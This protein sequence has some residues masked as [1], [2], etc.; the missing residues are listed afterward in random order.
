M[1]K[2]NKMTENNSETKILWN[3]QKINKSRGKIYI[4]SMKQY[5]FVF[6]TFVRF[7]GMHSVETDQ[8]IFCKM[9]KKVDRE[10]TAK[11]LANILLYLN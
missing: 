6:F 8:T 2:L 7:I 9:T 3:L 10:N 11:R 5:F 1:N 4:I